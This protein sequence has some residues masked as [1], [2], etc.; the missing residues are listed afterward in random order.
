VL[1]E[2]SRV[3]VQAEASGVEVVVGGLRDPDFGPAVLVGLGGV[4]VE[5]LDDVALALAPLHRQDARRL[6]TSL[7]GH[8]LLEGAR[9]TPPVDLDALARLIRS[10]GDLV[11]SVPEIA[12]VDLNPVLATEHGCL[13]VDGRILV[14]NRP[15]QDHEPAAESSPQAGE[16]SSAR[17]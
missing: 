3:L 7:R 5:A 2:G 14:A 10:V 4:F 11:A 15:P 12:E 13:A 9:G 1:A 17:P 16:T 6:L 8:P